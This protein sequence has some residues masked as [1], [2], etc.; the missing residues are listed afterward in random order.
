M[1][2]PP[3]RAHN[4][5]QATFPGLSIPP[6]ST[7]HP[8]NTTKPPLRIFKD[9]AP[10]PSW[11]GLHPLVKSWTQLLQWDR[12]WAQAQELV[13]FGVSIEECSLKRCH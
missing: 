9:E 10:L 11:E 1:G 2:L 8:S 4:R 12:K 6:A 7:P 5:L 13:G 3:P